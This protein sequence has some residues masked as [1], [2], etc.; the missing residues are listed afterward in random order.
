MIDALLTLE[1]QLLRRSQDGPPDEYGNPAW[2]AVAEPVTCE[3]QQEGATEAEG[4]AVQVSAWRVYLAAAAAD[5]RGWDALEVAGAT[6][7]VDGDA[8]TVRNPRTG[9]ISHVE[10]RVRRVE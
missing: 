7:E 5:V 10:A 8:W 6:Y 4:G 2:E 3:L 9:A 1:A